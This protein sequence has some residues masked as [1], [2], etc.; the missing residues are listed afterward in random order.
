M[1][2]VLIATDMFSLMTQKLWYPLSI[3]LVL[4]DIVPK[5]VSIRAP[6]FSENCMC[7]HTFCT[8]Y[9]FF[10]SSVWFVTSK[11]VQQRQL[12]QGSS[13]QC[14][15]ALKQG[16]CQVCSQAMVPLRCVWPGMSDAGCLP[17]CYA[18]LCFAELCG[19]SDG[20]F[21]LL[22]NIVDPK[23]EHGVPTIREYS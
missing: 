3:K 18:R 15:R 13:V 23:L 17:V 4:S 20:G 5:L 12:H 16:T 21:E 7:C 9:R 10:F 19:M 14:S 8:V 22:Y 11:Y 1:L 6:K 2:V